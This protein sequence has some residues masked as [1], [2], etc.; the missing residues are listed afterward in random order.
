[1]LLRQLDAAIS[2][3]AALISTCASFSACANVAGETGGPTSGDVPN[4]GGAPGGKSA[5]LLTGLR[6]AAVTAAM[7]ADTRVRN[8]RRDFAMSHSARHRRFGHCGTIGPRTGG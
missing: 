6:Q 8:C 5:A 3:S 4:A 2:R 7:L 1:M